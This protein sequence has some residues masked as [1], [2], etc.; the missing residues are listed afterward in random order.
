MT[1]TEETQKPNPM[2]RCANDIWG[3]CKTEPQWAISPHEW[4]RCSVGGKCSLNKETCGKFLSA[5]ELGQQDLAR[6]KAQGCRW[7]LEPEKEL[8]TQIAEPVRNTKPESCKKGKKSAPAK[9][10]MFG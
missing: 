2:W 4:K 6:A 1:I 5:V 10:G 7:A 8:E 3:Y 9:T